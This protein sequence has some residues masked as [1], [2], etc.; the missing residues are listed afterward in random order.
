MQTW[1]SIEMWETR[2]WYKCPLVLAI[3]SAQF[4]S[5]VKMSVSVGPFNNAHPQRYHRKGDVVSDMKSR[6]VGSTFFQDT[7]RGSSY[8]LKTTVFTST[9][10]PLPLLARDLGSKPKS[11]RGQREKVKHRVLKSTTRWG[12]MFAVIQLFSHKC[13]LFPI[14][15]PIHLHYA[16]L[17]AE[18]WYCT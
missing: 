5:H 8:S 13:I 14:T 2:A 6:R 1:V 18:G 11:Q 7:I 12:Q 16:T 9:P 17:Y 4:F 15:L 10:L 3:Q